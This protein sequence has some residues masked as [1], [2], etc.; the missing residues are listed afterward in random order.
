MSLRRRL[1]QALIAL[2]VLGGLGVLFVRSVRDAHSEPYTIARDHLRTWEVRIEPATA[3][4]AALLTLRPVPDLSS[5][6]F[7]QVFA[8]A[9]TSL[10][11][12]AGPGIPLLLRAEFDD[13]FRGAT[14]VEV[15]AERARQAGLESAVIQP[16]CL[17]MRRVSEPRATRQIYFVLFDAP[18]VVA[19]RDA[20]GTLVRGGAA[21]H[22]PFDPAALSPVLVVGASEGDFDRWYP[23]RAD[24]V[25]DCVAPIEI[26]GAS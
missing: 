21:G 13:A 26:V 5:G 9:M 8:R 7:R 20:L 2:A 1:F 23:L 14:A 10:T 6:L 16:R 12:P 4:R 3:P 19:F 22:A 17:A 15:L 18:A 24:P 25:A 11:S